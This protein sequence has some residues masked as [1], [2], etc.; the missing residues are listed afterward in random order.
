ML[1]TQMMTPVPQWQMALDKGN[2][3]RKARAEYKRALKAGEKTSRDLLLNPPD[4]ALDVKIVDV[5][6]WIPGIKRTRA[7][8]IMRG[9]VFQ[10][11]TPMHR[12]SPATRQK[13]YGQVEHYRPT[14]SYS[15]AA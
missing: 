8:R 10:E 6:Q 15:R 14:Y 3:V 9:I 13:L 11:G 4:L 1:E 7:L 12:L 2:S 5:L